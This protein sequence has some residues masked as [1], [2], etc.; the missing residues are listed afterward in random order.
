MEKLRKA[1]WL[2]PVVFI[3]LFPV[4]IGGQSAYWSGILVFAGIYVILA[5]GLDLLMGFTGQISVGHAAFF[6][7]GA[8]TSAV[9]TVKYGFSPLLAMFVGMF[10]SGTL[11]WVIGRPVL[12]LKEYYLAMATLAFNEIIITLIVGFENITGGASGLRDIPPFSIFGLVLSNHVHYYYFVWAVV[13]IV[14]ASSILIIRSPFG[15]TLVAIHSDEVAARTFGVDCA[16][17]K[18]RVFV[19]ANVFASIAG[20]LF[21]HYM[22]FIAPDDFGVATSVN[23]LV[24]LFLGGIGTIYGPI[25]GAIFLKL[26]P[27]ATYLVQD[28]ELL[29]NGVILIIV[30]IFMPKGIF[31][32]FTTLRNRVFAKV[33]K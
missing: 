27:E 28:Y 21:A 33:S 11:A 31:G 23:I 15:R 5:V 19:L 18:T 7:V 12:A 6:A 25:L 2:I 20:S 10:L 22:G 3:I 29:L 17:Y 24:M 13:L 26:L 4:T 14:I 30:L 9:L 16:E 1:W 32:L 8:Y